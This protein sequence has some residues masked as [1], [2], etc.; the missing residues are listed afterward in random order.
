MIAEQYIKEGIRIRKSYINNIKEIIEQEPKISNK[1]NSFEKLKNEMEDI[2]KSD[3][4]DIRK[5]LEL[6]EKLLH[7]EKEI[8][9][10]QDVIRPFYDNIENLRNERDKLYL[11]IIEKYPNITAKEIEHDIMSHVKE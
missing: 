3:I 1:K 11:A 6:N 7:L 4:N 8:K 9:A 10:I 5:T 2:V